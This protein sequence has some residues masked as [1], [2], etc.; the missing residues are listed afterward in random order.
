M[1]IIAFYKP[2]LLNSGQTWLLQPWLQLS[3][4]AQASNLLLDTSL[5]SVAEQICAMETAVEPADNTLAYFIQS[6]SKP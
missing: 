2:D 4:E 5:P 6:S 3:I 1:L